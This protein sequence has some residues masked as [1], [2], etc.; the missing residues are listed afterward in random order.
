M[1]RMR[2]QGR[3]R[4]SVKR[5]LCSTY[6]RKHRLQHFK[7]YP[8]TLCY[9]VGALDKVLGEEWNGMS[10]LGLCAHEANDYKLD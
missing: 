1:T 4:V 10:L 6:L 5:A 7:H 2:E 3:A 8:G 9:P